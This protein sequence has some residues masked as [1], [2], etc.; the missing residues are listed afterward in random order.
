MSIYLQGKSWYYEF[1][2]KG[3]GYGVQSLRQRNELYI[4]RGGHP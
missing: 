4:G 1:V 3:R 2:R